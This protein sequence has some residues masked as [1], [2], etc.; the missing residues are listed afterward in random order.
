M[1]PKNLPE[2]VSAD[3]LAEWE[4]DAATLPNIHPA[5]RAQTQN[6]LT[7]AKKKVEAR[8]RLRAKLAARK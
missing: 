3:L 8:E 5:G 2:T 4:F 7:Q 1:A 6:S